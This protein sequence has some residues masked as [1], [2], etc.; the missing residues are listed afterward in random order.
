MNDAGARSYVYPRASAMLARAF[1]GERARSLFTCSSIRDLYMKVFDG[2][3]PALPEVLL[4][5]DL[6]K[7]ATASFVEE[8]S[9]LLSV[10]PKPDEVCL[11]LLSLYDYDNL[12]VIL[13]ALRNGDIEPPELVNTG[14]YST[15]FPGCWPNLRKMTEKTIFSWVVDDFEKNL[16]INIIYNK[17]DKQYCRRLFSSLKEL[18][19]E[20]QLQ[21]KSILKEEFILQNIIWAMRLR[22]YHK[23]SVSKIIPLLTTLADGDA[24]GDLIAGPA[25]VALNKNFSDYSQWQKWHYSFLVNP[26][27]G[28]SRW[29]FDPTY[30]EQRMV[31]HVVKVAHR[32]FRMNQFSAAML[33]AFFRLKQQELAYIRGASNAIHLNLNINEFPNFYKFEV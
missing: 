32:A 7:T 13:G 11:R 21:I 30:F 9:S 16:P 15:F 1:L 17:L 26:P 19:G 6:E 18:D 22:I 29:V 10:F 28:S 3:P 12:K 33:V 27:D 4:I 20:T 23:L 24:H 25:V 31:S 8:F 2:E 5:R 14:K